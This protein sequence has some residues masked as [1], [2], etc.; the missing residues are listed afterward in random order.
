MPTSSFFLYHL[1]LTKPYESLDHWTEKDNQ[2]I[3]NHAK[4]LSDLGEQGHLLFAGRTTYAPGHPNLFGIAVIKAESPEA[5]E[6]LMAG[7]PAVVHGIQ[8]AEIHPYRMALS[9]FEHWET[10][11]EE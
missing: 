1:K 5:A 11:Q 8:Q 6:Q 9:F 4:F 10:W 7:D 2:I 3:S